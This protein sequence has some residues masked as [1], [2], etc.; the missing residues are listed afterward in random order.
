MGAVVSRWEHERIEDYGTCGVGLGARTVHAFETN[1]NT[2]VGLTIFLFERS[3]SDSLRSAYHPQIN[4]WLRVWT[5]YVS[6]IFFMTLEHNLGIRRLVLM[7]LD[8]SLSLSHT[9]TNTHTHPVGLL[10]TSDQPVTDAATYKTH[11]KRKIRTY[12]P[13]MGF[14]PAIPTISTAIPRLRAQGHREWRVKWSSLQNRTT[15]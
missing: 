10:C 4:P 9:H 14:E 13:S 11:K 8:H 2:N 5:N 6:G 7:F 3:C 1:L 12:M 15:V